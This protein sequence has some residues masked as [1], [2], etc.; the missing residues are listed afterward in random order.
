MYLV[1]HTLSSKTIA[2]PAAAG[3]QTAHRACAYKY[4]R[5]SQKI[6]PKHQ[7][8]LAPTNRRHRP[9]LIDPPLGE[10]HRSSRACK[11]QERDQLLLRSTFQRSP[12]S[13]NELGVGSL[14]G[15]VFLAPVSNQ[16]LSFFVWRISI[17]G[18]RS[19]LYYSCYTFGDA[20][21]HFLDTK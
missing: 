10:F 20:H 11:K 18:L 12:L 4:L 2:N 7:L 13:R 6:L 8:C 19:L 3:L 9:S 17:E 21:P 15:C 1:C 16:P 5:S 14:C